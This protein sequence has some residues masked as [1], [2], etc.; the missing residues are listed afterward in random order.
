MK[1]DEK[2]SETAAIK[3]SGGPTKPGRIEER[4]EEFEERQ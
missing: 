1:E 4:G 2:K 3:V